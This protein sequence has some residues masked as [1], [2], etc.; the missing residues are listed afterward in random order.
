MP[1]I[2]WLSG[3]KGVTGRKIWDNAIDD[4]LKNLVGYLICTDW[5]L[6]LHDKNKG[7]YLNVQ[8]NIV[9]GTVLLATE[10]SDILCPR[11]NFTPLPNLQSNCNGRG[12]SF[13]VRHT[14]ICYKLG[15]VIAR[16][17]E[18]REELF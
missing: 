12:T 5:C 9:T 13:D 6:L 4:K 18:V 14:L 16:H 17:N 7:V 2:F 10:F 3:N 15:L 1:I 11:Y 8:G